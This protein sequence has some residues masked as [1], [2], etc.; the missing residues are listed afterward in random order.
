MEPSNALLYTNRAAAYLMLTKYKEAIQD[1]DQALSLDSKCAKAYLRKATA[2]KG[3][4]QIEN[5]LSAI[6]GALII[7]PANKSA[8]QDQKS[9]QNVTVKLAQAHQLL[10]SQ[11]YS[12]AFVI[13]EQL[14]REIGTSNRDLN[15][16]KVKTLLYLKRNEE[17]LNLTNSL[18]RKLLPVCGMFFIILF[19]SFR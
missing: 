15:M 13:I 1:C 14:T 10:D 6:S 11:Q 3:L 16:M 7:D 8:L 12:A 2:L 19:S 9:L 4:G 18:V 17:A 5:A